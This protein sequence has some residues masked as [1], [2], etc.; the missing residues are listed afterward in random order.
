MQFDDINKLYSSPDFEI[1]ISSK[2]KLIVKL[3][4]DLIGYDKRNLPDFISTWTYY[5]N[6]KRVK[7]FR[8]TEFNSMEH[9]FEAEF[10]LIKKDAENDELK[11]FCKDILDIFNCANTHVLEWKMKK[12]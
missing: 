2:I 4:K 9:G 10:I 7:P 8:L 12:L 5:K 6:G 3:D 11:L 1:N